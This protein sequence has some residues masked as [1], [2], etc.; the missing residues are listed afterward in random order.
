MFKGKIIALL[1]L[2]PAEIMQYE[3]ELAEK[4]RKAMIKTLANQQVNHQVT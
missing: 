3:K 4:K 1:S 2:T